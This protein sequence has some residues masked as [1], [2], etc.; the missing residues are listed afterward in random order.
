MPAENVLGR[1][2]V[3][4]QRFRDAR[5]AV[6]LLAGFSVVAALTALVGVIGISRVDSLDT[7]V[8]SM[9][10][11][12]TAAISELGQARSEY[13]TARIQGPL[14]G[15]DGTPAGVAKIR[16]TWQTHIDAITT[17]MTTYRAT[18]MTG[19][20]E[21]LAAFDQAFANYQKLVPHLWELAVAGDTQRLRGLPQRCGLA[22]GG[23]RDHRAG[24]VGHDRGRRRPHGHHRS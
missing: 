12:S 13:A 7:A 3:D 11:N 18:D 15:L 6:K 20:Q 24:Q 14:A 19:R 22:A 23:S 9:Y 8:K 16:D 2:E 4:V 5:T 10:V 21:Q 17:A 1:P